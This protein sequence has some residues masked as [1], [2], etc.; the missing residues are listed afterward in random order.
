MSVIKPEQ[1]VRYVA[2]SYVWQQAT[3]TNQ[4]RLQKS[5]LEKLNNSERLNHAELPDFIVDAIALCRDIGED[6]LWVDRLCI[7]QDDS[8]SKRNQIC[9]MDKIYRSA[10]FTI[11][12][13]SK[14][15][16]LPGYLERPRKSS[17]WMPPRDC[18]HEARGV[19]PATCK[20]L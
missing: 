10:A 2:L 17:I 18:A 12:T 15:P 1:L 13:A 8:K 9:A 6:Y 5:N 14:G 16:G 4:L 3:A 11:I 20:S 19:I 7:V